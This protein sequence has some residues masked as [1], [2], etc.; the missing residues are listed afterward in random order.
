MMLF[1]C[2]VLLAALA[3]PGDF[4]SDCRAAIVAYEPVKSKCIALLADG[5]LEEANRAFLD[6]V[7][8]SART[9]AH[10]FVLGNFL[11]PIDPDLSSQL[12]EEAFK[13]DP[14]P[15]SIA[16]EWALEQ[17]RRGRYAEAEALYRRLLDDPSIGPTLALR[18]D[19]LLHLGKPKEACDSWQAANVAR[20]H[21]AV[22]QAACWV[23]GDVSPETRRCRLLAKA[24]AGDAAAVEEAV[25]LDLRWDRDWWNVDVRKDYLDR[26]LSLAAEKLGKESPRMAALAFVA[27]WLPPP[28]DAKDDRPAPSGD[29]R[30][31]AT[32]LGVLG[33][34]AKLP[35][36]TV[37]ASLV[38]SLLQ[39]KSIATAPELL[40]R[41]EAPL[42]SRVDSKA[43]DVDALEILAALYQDTKSPKLAEADRLGWERHADARFAAS[44]LAHRGNAIRSDDPVLKA[45]VAKLPLDPRIARIAVDCA[46]RDGQ[47][48]AEPLARLA[49]AEF[50]H[51][52]S[53]SGTNLAFER[54]AKALAAP[55]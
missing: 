39:N 55:K 51:M 10:A 16:F 30:A 52:T 12:H 26:D 41:F 29:L 19:C 49:Q 40:E 36:S 24:R 6:A 48:M 32:A 35:E 43:G 11:Y 4:A 31:E 7:P 47:P 9:A 46:E 54:L 5:R 44:L 33:P 17:H 45:A 14:N 34:Q 37:V 13:K 25:L 2:P 28:A 3:S 20:T 15:P 18:A 42:R 38:L 22:E 50:A 8:E 27:K 23:H 53:A 1:A 21:T